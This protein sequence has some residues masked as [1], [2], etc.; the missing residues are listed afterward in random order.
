MRTANTAVFLSDEFMRRVEAGEDWYMFDPKETMDLNEL[1]GKAFSKRYCEYV[2]LAKQGKMRMVRKVPAREQWHAI[3]TS[4]QSTSHPWL[5][6]KDPINLRALNN[7]TGTIHMS[8]LCTEICLPQDKDNIA[9]CNLA[10]VNLAAHINGKQV[11]WHKLEETVRLAVR[12][13]DNLIDINTLPIPEAT[14]SD[15]ENRAIGLGV[16]GFSDAL[17]QLSMSYES[18]HAWDFADR[19]FEFI[20]YMAI[21]E[22]ANLAR[23]RGSYS[24]FKG[25]GWSKGMVPLDT[26]QTLEQDRGTT[27]DLPK[28]T[29]QKSLDWDKLRAKVKQGMR[30]ATLM[31]VAPNAN[32]GL[33]AGTTPG[34]DPRFAQVFSRNKISGKYL[35]LNH[36]LVKDLKNMGLWEDVKEAII[37]EQGNIQNIDGLPQHLKEIY[38][39][40]FT[41]SAHAYIEVVARAQKWVDRDMDNMKNVYMTAWR[42][43]LKTTYY[44]HMK[45]RHTA[46]QSTTTVNKQEMTGK[47]GFGAIKMAAAAA[48]AEATPSPVEANI[49]SPMK[50]VETPA[51]AQVQAKPVQAEMKQAVAES[52]SAVAVAETKTAQPITS[53]QGGSA[54]GRKSKSIDDMPD[55]GADSPNV[56]IACQ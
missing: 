40:A 3:L 44:L 43:G 54:L 2:E 5:T 28:I 14:K 17:E 11:E 46:E 15:R 39:T 53:A 7:N 48:P 38:K 42:K 49:P 19:I 30:N 12:H 45:P 16:M 52:E 25:S 36:N 55:D 13:L 51:F 29:R 20:S 32:I 33:V 34:I 22:S 56:C 41:T 23:T 1:Y 4:L 10:S 31:A 35:D 47:R 18:P 50:V 6:W 24:H 26:I 8:N 37:E 27:I 21:D 9:V